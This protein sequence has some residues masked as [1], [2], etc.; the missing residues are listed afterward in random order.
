MGRTQQEH[1]RTSEPAAHT[2]SWARLRLAG[3]LF[4]SH[5]VHTEANKQGWDWSPDL[6]NSQA[7]VLNHIIHAALHVLVPKV[8]G[9]TSV[10]IPRFTTPQ[11]LCLG[12]LEK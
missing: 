5:Q 1:W 9:V 11:M 12:S 8:P 4:F 2:E 6:A 10:R 7:P 3:L